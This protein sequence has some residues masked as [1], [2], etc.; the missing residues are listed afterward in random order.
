MTAVTAW[1]HTQHNA[2]P[3][4]P[5]PLVTGG[6]PLEAALSVGGAPWDTGGGCQDAGPTWCPLGQSLRPPASILTSPRGHV[7][8]ATGIP[9]ASLTDDPLS[10]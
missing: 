10:G 4:P 8:T 7:L 5:G 6:K 3:L 9:E 1:L 2:P